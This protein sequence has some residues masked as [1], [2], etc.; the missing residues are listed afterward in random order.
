VDITP[1]AFIEAALEIVLE[2]WPGASAKPLTGSM[3]RSNLI[4]APKHMRFR[5]NRWCSTAEAS[6]MQLMQR[7]AFPHGGFAPPIENWRIIVVII[8]NKP[9][10]DWRR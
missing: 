9:D 4:E 8:R 3:C 2:S 7:L 10:N 1:L 5:R 6:Q